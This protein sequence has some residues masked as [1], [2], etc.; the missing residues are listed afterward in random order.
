MTR[1]GGDDDEYLGSMFSYFPTSEEPIH[2]R[3][4]QID[5]LITYW[6]KQLQI[7]K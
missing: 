3:E 4:Y 1:D 7:Y 5:H 2:S 6:R